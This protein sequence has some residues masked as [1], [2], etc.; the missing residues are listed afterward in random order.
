MAC[1]ASATEAI[2]RYMKEGEALSRDIA[3]RYG[4]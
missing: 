1:T 2:D 4:N 3:A